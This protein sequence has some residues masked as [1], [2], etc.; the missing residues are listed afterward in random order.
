MEIFSNFKSIFLIICAFLWKMLI[1]INMNRLPIWGVLL[2]NIFH[3]NASVTRKMQVLQNPFV[4]WDLDNYGNIKKKSGQH[5]QYKLV[6]FMFCVIYLYFP[7]I[8]SI[9]I[10]VPDNPFLY[11]VFHLSHH[12]GQSFEKCQL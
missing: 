5:R 1:V 2:S 6:L 11:N 9:Q 8:L 4:F 10:Q 3:E 12:F 7:Q